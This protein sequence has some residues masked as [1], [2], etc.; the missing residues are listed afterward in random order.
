LRNLEIRSQRARE[1]SEHEEQHCRIQ[2]R[3]KHAMMSR[4]VQRRSCNGPARAHQARRSFRTG[5]RE[6]VS[7][8]RVRFRNA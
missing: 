6:D 1:Q 2:Q 7:V 5:F 8:A 4:D 3:V